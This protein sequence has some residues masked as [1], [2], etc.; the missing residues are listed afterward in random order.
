MPCLGAQTCKLSI[1]TV[2]H[3]HHWVSQED[4]PLEGLF[5]LHGRS[6]GQCS[7]PSASCSVSWVEVCALCGSVSCSLCRSLLHPFCCL[8]A[9]DPVVLSCHRSWN[10]P[11]AV[12]YREINGITGLKGT[13]VNIQS[14]VYGNYNDNSGTGVCFTRNPATGDKQFFGEYLANAQ[15]EDVVA[16][17]FGAVVEFHYKY[18]STWGDVE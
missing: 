3:T 12:K 14:M 17:G 16:G 1:S 18:P 10:I 11:R 6:E 8:L 9:P 13:A 4:V 7:L 15:G 2:C 5:S